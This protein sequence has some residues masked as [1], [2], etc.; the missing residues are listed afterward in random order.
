[1]QLQRKQSWLL[2]GG[3]ALAASA[4]AGVLTAHL[5]QAQANTQRAL[6]IPHALAEIPEYPGA[7]FY[8]MGEELQVDG[9][10]RVMAYAVTQDSI[11][12]VA[13]HYESHWQALGM[14]VRREEGPSDVLLS[15]THVH[16]PIIRTVVVQRIEGDRT[17][18][19]ASV[20]TKLEAASP[21]RAVLPN[22]CQVLTEHG[23]RDGALV[24]ESLLLQCSLHLREV[25]A[26]YDRELGSA[27]RLVLEEPTVDRKSIQVSYG[28]SNLRVNLLATQTQ[29]QPPRTLVTLTWQEQTP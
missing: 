29:G 16:D 6:V 23:A 27:E 4:A 13:S 8:P 5:E 22:E 24:T 14:P 3:V 17:A 21:R 1:M 20:S 2:I 10:K 28:R 19:V 7:T 15:A 25:M 12:K 18:V 11:Y 9:L 26:F